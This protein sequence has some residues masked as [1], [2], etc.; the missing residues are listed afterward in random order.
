[1]RVW[2]NTKATRDA[3]AKLKPLALTKTA[4]AAKPHWKCL[5]IKAGSS[6][7]RLG[8]Y[9]PDVEVFTH[10]PV[11]QYE[12]DGVAWVNFLGF[13]KALKSLKADH[14][15]V[16]LDEEKET[17]DAVAR[18]STKVTQALHLIRS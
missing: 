4:K 16:I 17:Y 13:E 3:I 14:V 1:M 12:S 2:L 5:R 8:L 11:Q 6:T 18:P 7:V 15:E 9:R 10:V